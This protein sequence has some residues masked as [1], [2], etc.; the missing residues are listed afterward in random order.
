MLDSEAL[1]QSMEVAVYTPADYD[2]NRSYP[3][4]YLLHGFGGRA[5]SWFRYLNMGD[6]AD[7][8]ANSGKIDPLIIVSP[9]Y[10]NSFGVNSDAAGARVPPGVDAGQYEDYLIRELIPAIDNRY[11]TVRDKRGRSIGGISMG[12]YAALVLGMSNPDLFASIGAYSA[13][14]WTY[15]N[16][17]LY[18]NQREWLFATAELRARRD[19]FL[20]AAHLGASGVQ[21]HFD[22]GSEDPLA[23]PNRELYRELLAVGVTC[24]W[25]SPPGNHNIEY[26][27]GRLASYL[28]FH[29]GRAI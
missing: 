17:D 27:S 3:V 21:I 12:G 6:E 28:C 14:L 18:P 29:A 24:S 1:G 23:E 11:H 19:P 7:R 22:V 5:H 9:D 13:S 20:L 15:H 4:L 10:G 2:A 26:W 8:L 16:T 25:E